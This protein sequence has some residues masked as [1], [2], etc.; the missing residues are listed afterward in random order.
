MRIYIYLGMALFAGVAVI[1]SGS[2]SLP[3]RPMF[4]CAPSQQGSIGGDDLL[5]AIAWEPRWEVTATG[6][7]PMRVYDGR[8]ASGQAY[9]LAVRKKR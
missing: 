9:E 4:G 8:D 2:A 6:D 1:V 5:H 7:P 3:T